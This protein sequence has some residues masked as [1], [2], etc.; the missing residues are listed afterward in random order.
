MNSDTEHIR[1]WSIDMKDVV[2]LYITSDDSNGVFL[3]WIQ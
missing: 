1:K 3:V 2:K